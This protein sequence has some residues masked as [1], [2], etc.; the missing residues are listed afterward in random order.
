[1]KKNGSIT[2]TLQKDLIPIS[3]KYSGERVTPLLPLSNVQHVPTTHIALFEHKDFAKLR[4]F[5]KA[6]ILAFFMVRS[7]IHKWS[8]KHEGQEKGGL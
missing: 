1:M 2:E 8:S 7:L 4:T 6:E 3:S 5:F